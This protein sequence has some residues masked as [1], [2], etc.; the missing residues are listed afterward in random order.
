MEMIKGIQ[1]H[2]Y[3]DELVVP[4]IENTAYE[5]ELTDSFAK[6]IEAYPKT[7]AV[8]VRNH[9]VYVWGDSW[10]SAKTQVQGDLEKGVNGAVPIPPDHVWKEEVIG[11]MIA[12]VEEMINADRKI[13]SLKQLLGHI[14]QTGFENNEL[15]VVVFDD[16]P[17]ALEKW[18]AF[19]KKVY[20][21]S[22]SSRLTQRLIF[23]NT[24]YGDLR[25]YLSGFFDAMVGNKKDARRYIEIS[26]SLGV[27]K[28]SEILFVTDVLQEAVA[29]KAAGLEVII[30]IRLGNFL[31]PDNHGFKTV[32]SFSEI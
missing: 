3:Y 19:G 27:D 6:A 18:H 9:G 28:P 8:L 17:K 11:A 24:N 7:T 30:S 2:G 20:I 29:A 14:W 16:V 31:L 1:G 15:K 10:I 32:H 25:K 23:G 21:Y 13:T 26:E 22:S 5:N 12:N 4:I